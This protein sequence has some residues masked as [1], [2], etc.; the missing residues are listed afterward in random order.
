MPTTYFFGHSGV[1]RVQL[2]LIEQTGDLW[3]ISV[4]FILSVAIRLQ[5]LLANFAAG[6]T[7]LLPW[8]GTAARKV[9]TGSCFGCCLPLSPSGSPR[10]F[11]FLVMLIR[12]WTWVVQR[13]DRRRKGFLLGDVMSMDWRVQIASTSRLLRGEWD[14]APA[15]MKQRFMAFTPTWL[16]PVTASPFELGKLERF[17]YSCAADTFSY[18]M[19]PYTSR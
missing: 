1:H 2:P 10:N 11:S 3:T 19:R 15:V 7:I 6:R 9:R 16:P 4:S 5:R 17:R 14:G 13:P 8:I 18:T 12:I